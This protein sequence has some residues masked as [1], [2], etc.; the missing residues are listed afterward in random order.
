MLISSLDQIFEVKLRNIFESVYFDILYKFFLNKSKN[1]SIKRKIKSSNE[2][3]DVINFIFKVEYPFVLGYP[4][5][6]LYHNFDENLNKQSFDF[7]R[8]IVKKEFNDKVILLLHLSNTL[9][10]DLIPKLSFY[11]YKVNKLNPNKQKKRK[12]RVES[13]FPQIYAKYKSFL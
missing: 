6:L 2:S 3:Q 9:V 8:G 5:R 12:L 7:L 10:S 11:F 13:E 4:Y 1:K